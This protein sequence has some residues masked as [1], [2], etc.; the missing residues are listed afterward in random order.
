MRPRRLPELREILHLVPKE[1]APLRQPQASLTTRARA[2]Y[3]R[4]RMAAKWVMAVRWLRRS[5]FNSKWVLDG[6]PG[7][8]R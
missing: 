7:W 2:L 8:N 5:G 3:G 6:A 4:T 1:P